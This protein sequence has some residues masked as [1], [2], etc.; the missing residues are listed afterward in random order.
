VA[1]RDL[2]IRAAQASPMG[3][4]PHRRCEGGTAA[5]PPGHLLDPLV[6]ATC[7]RCCACR[8]SFSL[9]NLEECRHAFALLLAAVVPSL[10]LLRRGALLCL[11]ARRSS[12]NLHAPTPA[13]CCYCCSVFILDYSSEVEITNCT[14]C[15]IFIGEG[16]GCGLWRFG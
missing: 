7:R 8:E 1:G 10:L 6:D 2:A 3:R 4:R 11:P 15:Q 12:L 5:P 14:N 9:K 16:A 13:C